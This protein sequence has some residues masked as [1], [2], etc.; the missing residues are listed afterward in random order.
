MGVIKK[1]GA[2]RAARGRQ[3]ELEFYSLRAPDI[4]EKLQLFVEL[5]AGVE[6]SDGMPAAE[7][8]QR[9]MSMDEAVVNSYK[10]TLFEEA[11]DSLVTAEQRIVELEALVQ[12]LT[13]PKG[14]GH[15]RSPLPSM[16]NRIRIGVKRAQWFATLDGEQLSQ[17]QAVKAALREIYAMDSDGNSLPEN[18]LNSLVN[19]KL[20]SALRT[21]RRANAVAQPD[22]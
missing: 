15:R 9:L 6:H 16:A 14:R 8:L 5:A 12:A 19:S 13:Q 1:D 2:A 4:Q 22:K 21:Y 3:S 20:E 7:L 17:R 18:Q 11:V 10:A